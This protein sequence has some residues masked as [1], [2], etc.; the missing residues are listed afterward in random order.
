M[1]RG[2]PAFQPAEQFAMVFSLSYDFLHGTGLPFPVCPVPPPP[3]P[4]PLINQVRGEEEAAKSQVRGRRGGKRRFSSPAFFSCSC[5]LLD[6][7]GRYGVD[8]ALPCL[9]TDPPVTTVFTIMSASY[10]PLQKGKKQEAK[11]GG[12]R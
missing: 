12:K 5:L 4:T 9:T 7:R 3:P 10:P 6:R 2:E 11:R 8:P 1:R